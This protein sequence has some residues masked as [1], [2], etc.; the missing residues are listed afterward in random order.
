M[1]SVR[2]PSLWSEDLVRQAEAGSR[3]RSIGLRTWDHR[4]SSTSESGGAARH[5]RVLTEVL[6]TVGE[7]RRVLVMARFAWDNGRRLWF[8]ILMATSTLVVYILLHDSA[9]A[10][11]L[12]RSGEVL[13]SLPLSQELLRLPMSLFLPTPFLPIWAASAQILVV[14]GLGELLLG[15]WLTV[16]VAAL[17]HFAATLGA[18]VMIELCPGNALCLPIAAAHLIDTGPSAAVTAVGA[19]LLVATRCYRSAA[20]LTG[21]L[22]IAGIAAPGLDG[23]EHLLALV[24]GLTVGAMCRRRASVCLA[25][26]AEAE[27]L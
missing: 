27:L 21:A 9:T 19:C 22:L 18:R 2:R 5:P 10:P 6:M 15:R 14:L 23:Q 17:G 26:R 13:A 12:L 24:C 11:L 3:E 1:R 7:L 20:V 25:A 8:A 4:L 16:V